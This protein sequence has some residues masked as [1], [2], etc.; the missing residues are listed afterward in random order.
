MTKKKQ[1]DE[2][3]EVKSKPKRDEILVTLGHIHALLTVEDN[4][5]TSISIDR[6]AI[7]AN[8]LFVYD[9]EVENFMDVF[10]KIIAIY[11]A[12]NVLKGV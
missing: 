1:E 3:L 4:K 9:S 12:L 8:S 10:R 6:N 5:V 7:F 11:E 2:K